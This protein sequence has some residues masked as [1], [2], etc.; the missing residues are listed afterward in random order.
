MTIDATFWVAVSFFIFVGALIYFKIP[1]KTNTFLTEKIDEIKKE[2]EEAEKL[3][4][5]ARNLLSE[6][7]N[8][9]DRSKKESKE[10]ISSAKIESEKSV[11]K[12]TQKFYEIIDERKKNLNLKIN[13][14]KEN[15]LKDIKNASI[16]IAIEATESLIKN[17]IDKNKLETFYN[18]SLDQ[19]KSSLK[20]MKS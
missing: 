8:K 11:I 13:Q 12:K 2:L 1:Q 9:I 19:T 5:E 20:K 14:I 10:I 15:A 18:K 16:K 6:Y 17:S 3:K 4:N 7:E